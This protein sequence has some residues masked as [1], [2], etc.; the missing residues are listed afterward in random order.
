MR[1]SR[2]L[3]AGVAVALAM[4]VVMVHECLPF[5]PTVMAAL[6]AT[7]TLFAEPTQAIAPSTVALEEIWTRVQHQSSYQMTLTLKKDT[8]TDYFE[9]KFVREPSS[10][11]IKLYKE[12]SVFAHVVH[13]GQREWVGLGTEPV[14]MLPEELQL[15]ADLG[16][17]ARYLIATTL[18]ATF[19]KGTQATLER[20]S[21][22]VDEVPCD[23]YTWQGEGESISVC[24]SPQSFLPVYAEGE[25]AG[26]RWELHFS[27]FNAPVNVIAAPLSEQ[28]QQVHFD[29]IRMA[30]NGLASFQWT[31]EERLEVAPDSGLTGFHIVFKGTYTQPNQAWL[32]RIW[33]SSQTDRPSDLQ[34]FYQDGLRW[35][36]L[37]DTEPIHWMQEP[38]TMRDDDSLFENADPFYAWRMLTEHLVQGERVPGVGR[39]LAGTRCDEYQFMVAWQNAQ[40]TD[41]TQQ[42]TICLTLEEGIPLHFENILRYEKGTLS[43]IWS[44]DRLDDPANVNMVEVPEIVY[45]QPYYLVPT[46]ASAP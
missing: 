37:G 2:R 12:G 28:P 6:Q 22:V 45:T 40:G 39:T 26:L 33:V 10:E 36:G 13:I 20:A 34:A 16:Q 21:V 19:P 41:V 31:F 7:P 14:W 32:A 8:E 35:F 23:W 30:L 18:A 38:P 17:D 43:F 1:T 44:L 4:A 15:F 25:G 29:D 24:L 46:P 3:V 42:A 9:A 11:Y 27:R 5:S